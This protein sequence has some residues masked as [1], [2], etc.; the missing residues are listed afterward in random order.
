MKRHFGS[1]ATR[2]IL[3]SG[4]TLSDSEH[5][6]LGLLVG[7]LPPHLRLKVECQFESYNLVQRE[8]DKRTLNFY[9]SRAWRHGVLP[10]SPLLKSKLEV[11]PLMRL[12]LKVAGQ[13]A[14][15]HVVLTSV[16]GRAFSVSFSR[17][18]ARDSRPEEYSIAKVTQ[19]W[20]SNFEDDASAA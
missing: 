19:A 12:S 6:L 9:R 17:P 11:A 20:L 7:E 10:V 13:P 2:C 15:L 3:G 18:V 14:L 16:G 1:W 5:H 8:I 4:V